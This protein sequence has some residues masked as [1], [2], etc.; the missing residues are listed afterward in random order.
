MKKTIF[1]I[2]GI[3]ALS[4]SS[5]S[6]DLYYDIHGKYEIPVLKEKLCIANSLADLAKGYP[7]GWIT[8]Y[9]STELISTRL[10]KSQTAKGE[11]DTLNEEQKNLLK[12]ADIGTDVEIN[13][14]YLFK[15]PVNN[16]V[17]VKKMHYKV[18]VVPE[19]E[20]EYLG[21]RPNLDTY[22]FGSGIQSLPKSCFENQKQSKVTFTID[23][24]GKAIN[25]KVTQ[26]TGEEK[27]DKKLLKMINE[28]PYWRP[29]ENTSGQKVKQDFVFYVGNGGC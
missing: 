14:S 6:Q 9:V 19:K 10:G 16:E 23:E 1:C 3:V 2:L 25:A 24:S 11:N 18:T 26:S 27:V 22:L 13:V 12:A 5:F 17:S 29:A 15:N 28:M 21:G 20:A 4:L 8:G 7:S